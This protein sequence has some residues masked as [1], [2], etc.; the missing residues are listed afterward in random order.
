MATAETTK[1]KLYE[2]LAY[3]GQLKS[4]AEAA[5]KDLQNTFKSKRHLFEEKRRTYQPTVEG[6]Q[7]VTEEQS[8]IQSTVADE[9][10][11]IGGIWGKAL[12][13]AY[14][15]AEGNTVARADV[16]LDDGTLLIA[17]APATAL[18]ELEKRTG[19]LQDLITAVPTLDP[20]KA[21]SPDP[22]R[23][24]GIY[25]A[26]EVKKHRTKKTF[27]PLV[28][29]APTKEHPAQVKEGWED[30]PV[31]LVVEQEWSGLITP[32]TK[33]E[34]LE[35]VEELRRAVKAARQRANAVEVEKRRIAGPLFAYAFV[36]TK[37]TNGNGH[38][39]GSGNGL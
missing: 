37:P 13:V 19:E 18:L 3:E 12:D 28:L 30:V 10:D 33:A 14:D 27:I 5:R 32:K 29:A 39:N 31:G 21:F 35:R 17:N 20:A 8:D 36:G 25:K 34:I 16:V 7:A 4:Q 26:R 9:L 38:G 15:V 23:P 2:M 11:W 1:P 6:A 24:A 22:D